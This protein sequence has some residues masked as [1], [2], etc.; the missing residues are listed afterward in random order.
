MMLTD[1]SDDE[2]EA[3]ATAMAVDDDDAKDA[4]LRA[5]AV[6]VVA[7]AIPRVSTTVPDRWCWE[8]FA[9]EYLSVRGKFER[10]FRMPL[11]AYVKLRTLLQERLRKRNDKAW[12]A[13]KAEAIDPDTT[14]TCTLR[15]LAGGQYIDLCG[16]LRICISSVY[17]A[18]HDGLDAICACPALAYEFP[19]T[20]AQVN[21]AARQFT[22]LS[23]NE[24]FTNCVGL[25]D[26][27]LLKIETPSVKDTDNVD[28][29]FSGHYQIDGLSVVAVVDWR[30]RFTYTAISKPGGS[31]DISAYL[32]C[33][34]PT[35]VEALPFGYYILGDCGYCPSEHLLT[36]FYGSNRNVPEYESY[37]YYLSE[38]RN[39]VEQAFGMLV[40]KFRI[41]RCKQQMNLRRLLRLWMGMTR[42]HNFIIDNG[43]TAWGMEDIIPPYDPVAAPD[44]YF[45]SEPTDW[46]GSVQGQ[47]A[48]R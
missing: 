8:S 26:G 10:F 16:L 42:L 13:T 29:Y 46:V 9:A 38:L 25:V 39:L 11:G 40:A 37:N 44:G 14:L 22:K 18:I 6:V 48:L 31:S 3:A 12:A 34:L 35:L 2:D 27:Y 4:R 24:V 1:A 43:G 41:L 28:S 20:S 23:T 36:P 5:C 47:S 17:R 33:K 7:A 19:E 32:G 30:R 15:Y 21:E 45:P